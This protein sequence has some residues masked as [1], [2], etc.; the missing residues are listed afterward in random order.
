MVCAAPQAPDAF[1]GA[2]GK[3]NIIDARGRDL[4]RLLEEKL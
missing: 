4:M 3:A 1:V 2:D